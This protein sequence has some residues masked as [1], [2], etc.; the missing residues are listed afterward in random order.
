MRMQAK[1]AQFVILVASLVAAGCGSD[2]EPL[3]PSGDQPP[4]AVL[5]A[6]PAELGAVLQHSSGTELLV[7]DGQRFRRAQVG[8]HPGIIAMTGIGLA[9]A[10]RVASLTIQHFAPRAVLVVGVAGSRRVPIGSV[11]VP[12]RWMLRDGREFT[13]YLP[14]WNLVH[15]IAARAEADLQRCTSAQLPGGPLPVCMPEAPRLLAV[16][17]GLSDDPFAGRPFPCQEGGDDLY[18]CDVPAANAAARTKQS[19]VHLA[20]QAAAE[21]SIQDMETAAIAEV[22]AQAG[23]PF[24]AF[25]AV[26]DGLGDPLSLGGFLAQFSAYYRYAASNAAAA[27]RRFLEFL[28]CDPTLEQARAG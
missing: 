17:L 1:L 22:A 10:R 3:C 19:P 12:R 2:G 23:I 18:G 20:T 13:V 27:A 15:R 24:V 25:R 8:R 14:W 7:V 16:D 21:P 6:F 28:P 5:S 26:S 11:V 9:N 4:L